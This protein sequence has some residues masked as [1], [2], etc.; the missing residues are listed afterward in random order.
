MVHSDALKLRRY[1]RLRTFQNYPLHSASISRI[2]LSCATACS[3]WADASL[4]C[5]LMAGQRILVPSMGVRLP[6]SQPFASYIRPV[7]LAVQDAALSRRRSPVRIWY[8]L[9]N[10]SGSFG[11]LFVSDTRFFPAPI[12][13]FRTSP[14]L[15][16]YNRDIRLIS[17]ENH[18]GFPST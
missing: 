17:K 5:R 15:S 16:G 12:F 2:F 13:R 4:G 9:P 8:G 10:I 7:R 18:V 14:Y 6:P 3:C 11:S 1:S